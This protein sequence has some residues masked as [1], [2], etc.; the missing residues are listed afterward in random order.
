MGLYYSDYSL[1]VGIVKF[2][3]D[4][5]IISDDMRSMMLSIPGGYI[6][7][8]GYIRDAVTRYLQSKGNDCITDPRKRNGL[9][10]SY[11]GKDIP[12][13]IHYLTIEDLQRIS[14]GI[15]SGRFC[16]FMGMDAAQYS[17]I[18]NEKHALTQDM[19]MRLNEKLD[20]YYSYLFTGFR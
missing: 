16:R 3:G 6:R 4:W 11:S 10:Y 8:E 5:Y 15:K 2:K 9:L 1:D 20:S 17:R 12:L 18:L 14:T 19:S 7:D 13:K